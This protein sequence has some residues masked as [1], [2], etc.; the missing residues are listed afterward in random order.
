[1]SM[2]RPCCA[3]RCEFILPPPSLLEMEMP[4]NQLTLYYNVC[5]LGNCLYRTKSRD[6]HPSNAG[7]SPA[8][9]SLKWKEFQKTGV[10]H[11][12]VVIY[13]S[14]TRGVWPSIGD[15]KAA[16]VYPLY[17]GHHS[18]VLYDGGN[19]GDVEGISSCGYWC[20]D[21]GDIWTRELWRDIEREYT[22]T[23][24]MVVY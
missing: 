4:L 6:S 7:V 15:G 14:N 22:G 12:S 9:G 13:G 8:M 24:R 5:G 1:M 18:Q 2:N 20:W 23:F 17:G 21:H 3:C 16:R 11:L 10:H 19:T